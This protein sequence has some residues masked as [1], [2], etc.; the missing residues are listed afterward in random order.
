M[1]PILIFL[2]SVTAELSVYSA[3]DLRDVDKV[4]YA[5][6]SA[7]ASKL[8]GHEDLI[9]P[10]IAKAC[11]QIMPK[12]P[13]NF[14]VDNVRVAKIL[15]SGIYDSRVMKGFVLGRDTEGVI[16]HVTNAKVAVYASGLDLPKTEGKGTVLIKTAAELEAFSKDEEARF[17]EFIKSIADTG[18]KVI[19]SGGP[20]GELAMHFAER[21][22]MMVVKCPSKFELQRICKATKSTAVIRVGPPMA[23]ELGFC[24]IVSVEEIGGSRVIV[25]RQ[26]AEDSAISTIIVRGSTQNMLDDVER[27][28]QDGVNVVKQ[29][30]KD[31]RFLAGAGAA[32]IELARFLI[33]EAQ[34]SPGLDQ[35][36]IRKFG[37]AL[38]GM[39]S[40][41]S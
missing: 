19:V 37:E 2:F 35:Y 36:A 23:E 26:D 10:L 8:F 29:M 39:F 7:I 20:I 1:K 11:V 41:P 12:N 21:Y 34:R 30:S 27:A 17:E 3:D 9:A 5:I 40:V 33:K 13:R 25:F 28:I 4:G 22:K 31:G 24:D 6:R 15:G 32:E 18:A 38:E 14:N 16:K